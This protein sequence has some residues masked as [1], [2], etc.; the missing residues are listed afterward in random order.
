M[1]VVPVVAVAVLAAT[2]GTK[3]ATAIL[4]VVGAILAGAVLAAVHHAEVIAPGR[5]ALGALILALSRHRHRGRA[6]RD[7]DGLGRLGD[8]DTRAR[9][10]VRG[11]DD[12]P[13]ARLGDCEHRAHDPRDRGRVD[14]ARRAARARARHDQMV[15]L[16]ITAAVGALTVLPGRAMVQ[17]GGV[18]V[19]LFG[20]F[21][22][23][24]FNP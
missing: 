21:V 17:E 18:Y 2:W 8:L 14:L 13:R 11:R 4:L 24:A 23:L 19:V 3:P 12:Q 6:D 7:A 22:F 15:L 10:R 20:A 1:T 5:G 16:A 9:H